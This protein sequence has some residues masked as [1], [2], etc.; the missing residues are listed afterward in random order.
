MS[1]HM[2]ICLTCN[3]CYEDIEESCGQRGHE[4]LVTSRLGTRMIGAKYRL[5]RLLKQ[6]GVS[7]VFAGTHVDL[8]RP[9][10][11]KILKP[12][13]ISQQT[14]LH[15]LK[16]EARIMA[17][18]KH[19]NIAVTYDYDLAPNGETYIVMEL[20]DGQNLADYLK[21]ITPPVI[22]TVKIM[23]Q[24]ADA[25]SVAHRQGIVHRDL[26]PANIMLTNDESGE[27]LAKLIDFGIAKIIK[28]VIVAEARLTPPNSIIGTYYYVSPE[29]CEGKTLDERADIYS[30]GVVLYRMLAGRPPFV[31]DFPAII[32]AH[33]HQ[34]PELLTKLR[35]DLPAQLAQLVMQCLQKDPATRPQSIADV[36]QRLSEIESLIEPRPQTKQHLDEANLIDIIGFNNI[37]DDSTQ[38]TEEVT[39]VQSRFP[40]S[41]AA[42]HNRRSISKRVQSKTGEKKA[43]K[44]KVKAKA[45]VKAM[46][47]NKVRIYDLAKE[48]KLESKRLIEEVRREGVDVSVPS[49]TISKELAEKI[50]NKYFPKKEAVKPSRIVKVAVAPRP[51]PARNIVAPPPQS[52]RSVVVPRA[53]TIKPVARTIRPLTRSA[54]EMLSQYLK[55][56]K[57]FVDTSSLMHPAATEAFHGEVQQALAQSNS[58]LAVPIR[59]LQEMKNH[60]SNKSVASE[61]LERQ[62]LA[63][64]GMRILS[65]LE[66][67][68]LCE[69]YGNETDQFPDALF[70]S[71]FSRLRTLHD[72]CLITQDVSM[73]V[74]V[75]EL[76]SSHSVYGIKQIT[77]WE[78]N[79]EG[80]LQKVDLAT[81]R[82]RYE[83]QR[84]RYNN[85]KAEAQPRFYFK[86][87]SHLYERSTEILPTRIEITE[88][89]TLHTLT[90]GP[91]AIT[92]EKE[93]DKG[94]E[95]HVFATSQLGLVA[96]IYH[97]QNLTKAACDKLKL[98]V[99]KPL[100]KLPETIGI[101]WPLDIL[102]DADGR[103]RGFLMPEARGRLLGTCVFNRNE[104]ERNFPDWDKT[105]LVT[106]CINILRRIQFLHNA[107]IIIGDLNQWNIFVED[108]DNVFLIDT[109]SYQV[110]GYPCPVGSPHFTAPELQG[111]RLPETLRSY[112]HEA[113]AIAAMLFMILHVGKQPYAQLGS[114]DIRENIRLMQFPYKLGSRKT[115][116]APE[117]PWK[118]IWNNLPYRVKEAFYETFH[119][120][121]RSKRRRSLA[122]WLF[123][124]RRYKYAL[125]NDFLS[126][127]LFPTKYKRV[128]QH[129]RDVF[130]VG[131]NEDNTPRW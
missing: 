61:A 78:I 31:A 108:E 114:D 64:K 126:K 73:M 93:L 9:V 54:D 18:L 92:L 103:P 110:E 101:C 123:L 106:L 43:G 35:P 111:V 14:E 53:A 45:R 62:K 58:R 2:K 55:T 124:L 28:Q 128:T 4:A 34:Q 109:D 77:I 107:N 50:R 118:I 3:H 6:G 91:H 98:M 90:H 120:D 74:D 115:E 125:D 29:E 129:A 97:T 56:A 39:L 116:K 20:V 84:E 127:E 5:D 41:K 23:R 88:G 44:K 113:F 85:N 76:Q 42:N 10:A 16:R 48:L 122:D 47:S 105:H 26:K 11:V 119:F 66:A 49:N 30:L 15:R 21:T 37:N 121:F 99:S 79:N 13:L 117:G 72:I 65:K 112:E 87:V 67:V 68:G 89:S 63:G 38:A 12:D 40:T 33:I 95:G 96:K 22:T 75:L 8:D 82:M 52:A 59:V 69:F 51:S 94:G 24:V 104:L 17:R 57:L 19:S 7:Y 36:A 86:S 81:A 60:Q 131:I 1:S 83:K 100:P 80:T 130:G 102:V 25:I 27:L 71:L 46:V 70:I 32:V